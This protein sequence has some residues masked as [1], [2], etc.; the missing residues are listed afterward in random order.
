VRTLATIGI[1]SAAWM[2]AVWAADHIDALF[3]IETPLK[4]IA[5]FTT[6]TLFKD[7]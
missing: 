5:V 4:V 7:P 6:L 2:A 3:L 1:A